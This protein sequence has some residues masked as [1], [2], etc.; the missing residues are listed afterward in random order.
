MPI[1]LCRI[2]D[3]AAPLIL[4]R[5]GRGVLRAGLTSTGIGGRTP[6]AR[7]P[8]CPFVLAAQE[9]GGLESFAGGIDGQDVTSKKP[10]WVGGFMGAGMVAPNENGSH[11]AWWNP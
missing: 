8:G 5:A 2:P 9:S 6:E 7:A 10:P 4:L 11:I 1:L 3:G